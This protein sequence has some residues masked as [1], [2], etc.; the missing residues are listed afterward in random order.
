MTAP[1]PTASQPGNLRARSSLRATIALAAL[2][3]LLAATSWA[4]ADESAADSVQLLPSAV[5]GGHDAIEPSWDA[6]AETDSAAPVKCE[7][8]ANV[9]VVAGDVAQALGEELAAEG[10][11]ALGSLGTGDDIRITTEDLDR[12]DAIRSEPPR[13]F[14]SEA[15]VLALPEDDPLR[16]AYEEGDIAKPDWQEEGFLSVFALEPYTDEYYFVRG[17]ELA[18]VLVRLEACRDDGTQPDPLPREVLRRTVYRV[19]QVD[20]VDYRPRTSFFR[21]KEF[22]RDAAWQQHPSNPVINRSGGG[23]AVVRA[24][25]TYTMWVNGYSGASGFIFR[26]TSA[27]GVAWD[28]AWDSAHT[29]TFEGLPDIQVYKRNP[30]VVRGVDGW[31]AWVEVDGDSTQPW[32]TRLHHTTSTD[33]LVWTKPVRLLGEE[34]GDLSAPYVMVNEGIYHLFAQDDGQRGIVHA[35]S[36]DGVTWEKAV[37]VVSWGEDIDD[38]DGFGAFTP[39][40]VRLGERWVMYYAAAY[41]PREGRDS[42][43]QP[44][45]YQMHLTY[46]TSPDGVTWEKSG[47]PIWSQTRTPG[48]WE[49]GNLGRP[50]P[51]AVGADAWVYYTGVERGEPSV[52]LLIGSGWTP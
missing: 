50:M 1:C 49:S 47:A 28:F 12:F 32:I 17:G 11:T 30:T 13:Y 14:G 26:A 31:E 8:S 45:W 44:I 19:A 23:A 22:P 10:F 34:L 46:A 16:E 4:C 51:L 5:D 25:D 33:G 39:A 29:C 9:E 43:Y 52:A 48:H 24:D 7:A 40:V 37:T 21:V 18:A 20:T 6:S 2:P 3:S 41:S 15:E 35:M 36:S 38:I 27:D 42:W